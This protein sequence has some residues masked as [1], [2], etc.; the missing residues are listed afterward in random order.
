MVSRL[1]VY[2]ACHTTCPHKNRLA[3]LALDVNFAYRPFLQSL[4]S[5]NAHFNDGVFKVLTSFALKSFLIIAIVI[6]RY[7]VDIMSR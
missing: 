1:I 7:H 5:P 3:L 2:L 6:F 4:L